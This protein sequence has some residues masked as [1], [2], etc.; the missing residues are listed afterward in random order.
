[1]RHDPMLGFAPF[2]R[3]RDFAIRL[4]HLCLTFPWLN[5]TMV[6]QNDTPRAVRTLRFER[7]ECITTL[8][9]VT[10]CVGQVTRF[11]LL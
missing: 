6:D 10:G 1:M 3:D 9:R 2:D 8:V 4:S 5:F 7:Q 11:L